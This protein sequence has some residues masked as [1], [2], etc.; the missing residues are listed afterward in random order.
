MSDTNPAET[1]GLL[2]QKLGEMKLAYLHN[3]EAFAGSPRDEAVIA[4]VRNRFDGVYIANGAYDGDSARARIE[5]GQADAVAFG[6]LYI[7]NPDLAKRFK[8]N[9]PLNEPNRETYYT[10]TAEAYADYPTLA[11]EP[12]P[13]YAVRCPQPTRHPTRKPPTSR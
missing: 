3:A 7:A 4:E 12:S 10:G 6:E 11:E 5:S 9:A 13:E 1:F 8:L 2:A